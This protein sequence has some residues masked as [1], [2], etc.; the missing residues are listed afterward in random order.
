MACALPMVG[1]GGCDV[2]K[3][4][5]EVRGKAHRM[6][7]VLLLLAL[8]VGEA[9]GATMQWQ[10]GS[11]RPLTVGWQQF[12]RVQWDVAKVSGRPVVEGYITNTWGFAAT[13]IRLL[14]NGYDSSGKRVGQLVAWGPNE[15]DPGSRVY[16]DVSVPRAA[17]YEVAIF[18][19][20]WI[21]SGGGKD[22]QRR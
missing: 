7:L 11:L 3:E 16:F 12:F 2:R 1:A 17:S 5:V 15:V 6:S 22:I 14:V 21:Q 10:R 8:T 19:W 20:N 18:S 4:I 9:L 13:D